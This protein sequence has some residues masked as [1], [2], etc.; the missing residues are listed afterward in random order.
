[1]K[2]LFVLGFSNPRP[3][4]AWERIKTFSELWSS[5]GHIVD[6][7]GTFD[8]TN[9]EKVGI[10]KL[11]RISLLNLIPWIARSRTR[12]IPLALLFNLIMSFIVSLCVLLVKRPEI[13]IISVPTGDIGLGSMIACVVVN[14]SFVLDFRDEWEDYG[15]SITHS[16]AMRF[17]Y[18]ILKKFTTIF[19]SRSIIIVTV[20]EGLRSSLR[21]RG[22][23]SIELVPNGANV[24]V[25]K[26]C[27]QLKLT[28]IFTVIYVGQIGKYYRVDIVLKAIRRLIDKG[29]EDVELVIAGWGDIDNLMILASRWE[30]SDK[31]RYLGII[32][33]KEK[34]S[35]E[36]AKS[37]VGVIPYDD[38]L[39]W[40]N[41]L[42][43]KFFEYCACGIPIV[44]SVFQDSILAQFIS[45]YKIGLYVPPLDD[46]SF[47]KSLNKLYNNPD[48][49][50]VAG[51]SA[52][53]LIETR[54]NR[55]NIAEDF[56]SLITK[57][58]CGDNYR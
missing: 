34:L 33:D 58:L 36:I 41:A 32:E 17:I 35:H 39:L 56:L 11:G 24:N 22:L 30:I 43:A 14:R 40:K 51:E 16:K 12:R 37:S 48:L 44:A 6:I 7:L 27:N 47:A 10:Q 20:T 1:M 9:L 31:V 21:K 25:F 29:I 18:N 55:E 2:I 4:A 50:R 13:V 49:A 19:Y 46:T 53:T 8:F 3:G 5:K 45:E 15:L 28:P 26:P 23:D 42:P 54:F 38:N 57:T 52:R